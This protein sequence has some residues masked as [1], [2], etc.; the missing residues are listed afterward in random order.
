VVHA[1]DPR[2]KIGCAVVL[3]LVVLQGSFFTAASTSVW[4]ACLARSS[5]VP[6]RRLLGALA[7]ARVFLALLF[8]LHLLFTG[9]TPIPSLEN[10]VAAVTYEGLFQGL[11]VSWQFALLLAAGAL[12]TMTTSPGELVDGLER[13]IRPLRVLGVRS[14]DIA[15]MVSLALRFV[16]TL[17]DEMRRVREAQEARGASFRGGLVRR[18]RRTVSLI[19]P[20]A[21]G[22]FRRGDELALAMEAR[23]YRGGARTGL[24]ELRFALRDYAAA[25]L[26]VLVLGAIAGGDRL[27]TAI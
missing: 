5:R 26:G 7:P 13:L 11:L 2:V 4:L 9:G 27:L 23:G 21:L 6:F 8:L 10:P 14:H 1:L 19:L 3:S 24:R 16:P 25:L 15:L 17:L 20:V 12:L 18:A 22:A